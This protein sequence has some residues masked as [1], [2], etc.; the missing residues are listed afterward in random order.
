M[1]YKMKG[2]KNFGE[3]TPLLQ[4]VA[5]ESTGKVSKNKKG[6]SYAIF[7]SEH[8]GDIDFDSYAGNVGV[9]PGD[10]IFNPNPKNIVVSSG[11]EYIMGGDYN[12]DETESSKKRKKG[13]KSYKT[14]D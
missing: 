3:G 12:L 1:G 2:I 7:G 5:G 9:N 13:P 6:E 11:D 4:K 10:T 8:G 14:T